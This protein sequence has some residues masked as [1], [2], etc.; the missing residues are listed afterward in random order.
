MRLLMI[1]NEAVPVS[2]PIPL[3][4]LRVVVKRV[5]AMMAL[6]MGFGTVVGSSLMPGNPV[7]ILSGVIAGAIV[8]PWIGMFLGLMGGLVKDSLVGG[9][10]GM[11]VAA[12]YGKIWFGSVDTYT[13][14]ICLI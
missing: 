13:L 12:L 6:W 10:N 14:N 3:P 9:V 4:P 1:A 8:L 11:L 7:G 2:L 5:L